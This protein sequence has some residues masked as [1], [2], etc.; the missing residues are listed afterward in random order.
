MHTGGV[1]DPRNPHDKA[2]VLGQV[3]TSRSLFSAPARRGLPGRLLA[4]LLV[5]LALTGTAGCAKEK[6]VYSIVT[7]HRS[8]LV[9]CVESLRAI[10]SKRASAP[11]PGSSLPGLTL[12]YANTLLVAEEDI[13][14]LQTDLVDYSGRFVWNKADTARPYCDYELGSVINDLRSNPT[15]PPDTAPTRLEALERDI[16]RLKTASYIAVTHT[17]SAQAVVVRHTVFDPGSWKGS[18]AVWDRAKSTWVGA[19]AIEVTDGRTHTTSG[20]TDM[21]DELTRTLNRHITRTIEE[22]L[23]KGQ[24]I[25]G[26]LRTL[27]STP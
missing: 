14:G 9:A 18:V 11:A 17:E 6:S 21:G 12:T 22:S 10:A 25:P 2:C 23:H 5:A 1:I 24:S 8:E 7:E 16:A 3:D 4:G 13:P 15:N 19:L 26:V 27:G 20:A